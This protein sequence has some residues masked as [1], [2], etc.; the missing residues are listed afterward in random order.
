MEYAIVEA[1]SAFEL[2]QKVDDRIAA[3]WVPSGGVAVCYY[4]NGGWYFCQAVVR[5]PAGE[6]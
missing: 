5:P 6:G 3:G 4:G 2:Q 1:G